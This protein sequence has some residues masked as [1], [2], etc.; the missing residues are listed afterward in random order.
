[1]AI[2]FSGMKIFKIAFKD[3]VDN[4]WKVLIAPFSAKYFSHMRLF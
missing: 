3:V 1:M 4:N 2:L